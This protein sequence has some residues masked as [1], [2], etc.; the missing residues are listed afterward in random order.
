MKPPKASNGR[1]YTRQL[2]WD[3][4]VDMPIESRIVGPFFT[5]TRDREGLINFGK[6]YVDCGDPT[7]YKVAQKLFDGDYTLWTVLMQCRW[8]V[9]A[10]ELW[11]K[12][13]DAKLKS[14]GLDKVRE[15]LRDGLAPQ[16]LAAAKYLANQEYRKD[17]AA[18][19]GRPKR[20]DVDR[21]AKELAASEKEVADDMARIRNQA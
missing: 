4:W 14:E 20:E 18:G 1:Y 16:Q 6:E 9:A 19:K 15:L 7:G 10:K 5:L 2:F 17:R 13:L 12:E 11:D 8:F 3:Q 21:A